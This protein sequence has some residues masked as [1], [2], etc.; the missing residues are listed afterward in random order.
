MLM[1]KRQDLIYHSNSETHKLYNIWNPPKGKKISVYKP[2]LLEAETMCSESLRS[3]LALLQGSSV[4]LR[5]AREVDWERPVFVLSHG[6]T[7]L[8][9]RTCPGLTPNY[10]PQ[11]A[12]QHSL[13]A[14]SSSCQGDGILDEDEGVVA[15]VFKRW[16]PWNI[17]TQQDA[18]FH[19]LLKAPEESEN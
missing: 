10:R 12:S 18:Q 4:P 2:R 16:S 5:V 15:F 9:V 11:I 7:H 14:L 8:L 13:P 6:A 1:I 17:V 19:F 3:H